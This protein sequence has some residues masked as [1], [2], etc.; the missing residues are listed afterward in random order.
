MYRYA[1]SVNCSET[2]IIIIY[3]YTKC[4]IQ[5]LC[6]LPTC[7]IWKPC[8]KV[9]ANWPDLWRW[10]VTM[11]DLDIS[12]LKRALSWD[13]YVCLNLKFLSLLVQHKYFF[14][15]WHFKDDIDLSVLPLQSAFS[16]S[17]YKLLWKIYTMN[18]V[19]TLSFLCYYGK[20]LRGD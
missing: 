13:T 19:N 11:H 2:T 8:S 4:R 12:S 20:A 10:R 7:L 6:P 14:D 3:A 18:V 15:L 5:Y 16:N 1:H 9:M 17:W